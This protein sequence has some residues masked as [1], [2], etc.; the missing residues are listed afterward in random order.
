MVR[1]IS[2]SSVLLALCATSSPQPRGSTTEDRLLPLVE[3]I[4]RAD[5][6]G[7]RQ[8]LRDLHGALAAAPTTGT[9]ESLVRYWRGFALWRRAINGFNDTPTPADLDADLAAASAEFEAALTQDPRLADAQAGLASCLGMRIFLRKQLDDEGR[10][11]ILRAK[12]LLQQAQA[13]EPANPRVLWARGPT[14]W[15]TPKGSPPDIA[16]Q[17]QARA[18]ATYLRGLEGLPGSSRSGPEPLRPTWGE[19]ELHMSLAWSYLN[20]RVPDLAQAELHARKALELVPSWHYV[21]DI[22]LPQIEAARRTV[23]R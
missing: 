16:D 15:W 14:E 1:P 3:E 4:R 12:A 8:R 9:S 17:R 23:A 5:Y 7:D 20:R 22:L 18:I 2:L 6:A 13:L 11:L 10:A 19:P 21:R